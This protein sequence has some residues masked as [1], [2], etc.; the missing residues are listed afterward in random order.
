[1]LL[2]LSEPAWAAPDQPRHA[3]PVTVPGA[4]LLVLAEAQAWRSREQ[5]AHIFWPDHP[6]SD[7]LH[8][9]RINLH[10]SRQLLQ[11]WGLDAKAA[12]TAERSRVRLQLPTDLA[13]LREAQ[14]SGQAG[15]LAR[16]NP[17]RWLRGWVLPHCDSFAQWA[18][19][20]GDKLHQ[21]WLAA[22]RRWM[23]A[24]LNTAPAAPAPATVGAQAHAHAHAQAP[25]GRAAQWQALTTS[26]APAVLLLGEPGAGKTTLLQVAYPQAAWLRG[27]EGL[28]GM[29]YRPLLDMLR[30]HLQRLQSMLATPSLRPYRLD[31]ARVL[32]ELA[33][34]EP[35]PPLDALTAQSRLAE[36]LVRACEALTPVLL[37]DD[38][39][40][41]DAATWQW[42]VMV[43]HSKRLPWRAAARTAE[44]SAEHQ[45]ALQ[46]LRN[47]GAVLEVDLPALSRDA[48]QEACAQRWPTEAFSSARLD[49]L[50]AAS[51]GNPFVLGELVAAGWQGHSSDAAATA[52]AQA[53]VLQRLH[54]LVQARLA[55]LPAA[56]RQAVEAA[57]VF[58][59][60]VP[61]QALQVSGD[62][63]D[64]TWPAACPQ[65]LAAGLL[66][67]DS[68]GLSC[69]HDLIRQ[70]V[71]QSLSSGSQ[72]RLHR[73]AALWLAG[74]PQA[75]ALSV[76]AHWRAAQEPQ[77][78]LAWCHR[79]ADQLK[80]RGRFDE[81]RALWRQVADESL[82]A[83]QS[84]R[85]QLE[86]AACDF[87]EDLARGQAAL[88]AVRAQLGAVADSEQHQLIESRVLSALVDNRVFAGDIARAQQHA[89]RLRVV[90][91]HLAPHERVNALEVLIELAM[92]E[93][94]IAAAWALLAQL[95]EATPQAPTLLSFEGQIHWFGGQV[96]AAYD[97][98]ARLLQRHPDYCSGITVENDLAVMLHALGRLEEAQDMARRSLKSW[99]GVAHTETLSL[100]VLG[101]VLTSSGQ[102]GQAQAALSQALALAQT[103]NSAGFVAE[104]QVRLARTLILTRQLSRA[105]EVLQA[106]APLMRASPEPLRVSQFVLQQVLLSLALQRT[107]APE[108]LTLLQGVLARSE[109]PLAHCRGWRVQ[110]E[111]ALAGGDTQAAAR[112]AQKQAQ[113]AQEAGLLE[114]LAEAWHLLLRA[115]RASGEPEFHLHTL[116]AQLQSLVHKQ[117]FA[118]LVF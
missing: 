15:A 33:P 78:A 56:A 23:L 118:D 116:A 54:Q 86:L 84:L 63:S 75:D 58:V 41:C 7:A 27:L 32:P 35:L 71:Q 25:G 13:E 91:P 95:R 24:S 112:H 97:S 49:L 45:Q 83:T 43:A 38:L 29:P 115:R 103:Q 107:P 65:A 85:A 39:Q 106:A 5:L 37:V 50:H 81:A 21:D 101:S 69:R 98:L 104:A 109:H 94:N 17:S 10:R 8:H 76:A 62:A 40:W 67:Q 61:A 4:L 110:G 9:L 68:S 44:L 93:P 117:G 73:H 100:L 19:E 57:A 18:Q 105:D 31:L 92:R 30:E 96:Q 79:G 12:M 51:G 108:D 11:R 113:C 102:H 82:D 28:H 60:A 77:T 3:V 111:L 52:H 34:D 66:R 55:R 1:M 2:L 47:A 72:V 74:Q 16:H 36:A 114:A 70:A 64:T 26:G 88:E 59:Q 42:L 20:V 6:A 22:H 48:L 46:S 99:Q 53:P 87:F 80:K 14:T 89:S 90:L